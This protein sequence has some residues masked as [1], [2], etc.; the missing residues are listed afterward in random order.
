MVPE[1]T[2]QQSWLTCSL[3]HLCN[4]YCLHSTPLIAPG[5]KPRSKVPAIESR[6]NL[7]KPIRHTDINQENI[8]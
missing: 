2:G 6:K 1:R 5:K 4:F 3:H 8:F 7:A